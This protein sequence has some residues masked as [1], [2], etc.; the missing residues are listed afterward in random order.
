MREALTMH[1]FLSQD[2]VTIRGPTGNT[3]ITQ[4]HNAWLE[5]PEYPDIVAW[6][7]VHELTPGAAGTVQMGYQTAPTADDTS[8]LALSSTLITVPLT[9]T[10]G[11]TATPLLKDLLTVPLAKW[12]RWQLTASSM[13][14]W[15]ITFRL[16]VAANCLSHR[17]RRHR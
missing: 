13:G 6:L 1:T 2:L 10:V 14:T 8:F 16:F 5:L 17:Q 9:V 11:V 12:F 7:D 15:D 4:G 3:T